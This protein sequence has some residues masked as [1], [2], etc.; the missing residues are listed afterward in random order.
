[1]NETA[2]L[3]SSYSF[4]QAEMTVLKNR[5]AELEPA[6]VTVRRAK[7]IRALVHITAEAEM[8][9]TAKRLAATY[10]E[11]NGPRESDCIAGRLEVELL[12]TDVEKLDRVKEDL[13]RESVF[14]AANRAF[15][16]RAVLRW[17]PSG[18]A[19]APAVRKFLKEFPNK[20]RGLSKLRLAR[21]AKGHG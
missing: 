2:S 4:Y 13:A 16:I 6:G 1:M 10:A 12:K 7:L 11:K 8:F 18:A 9:D 14:A 20:P 19:L 15:V 17:S 21:K 5:L 3:V